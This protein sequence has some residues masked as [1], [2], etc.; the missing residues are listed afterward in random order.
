VSDNAGRKA[1]VE[2]ILTHYNAQDAESYVALLTDD[3]VQADYR[4]AVMR[5]GKEKIRAGL[6]A[7]F[8]RWP[9][10]RAE[11]L[12]LIPVG[13][14]V[15]LHEKVYHPPEPRPLELVSVYSFEGDKC[16]RVEFIR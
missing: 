9:E 11:V 16:S 14:Y 8:D 7:S 6:Q 3:A 13:N 5:A 12:S 2:Q 15:V 1:L 4:G 10:Q